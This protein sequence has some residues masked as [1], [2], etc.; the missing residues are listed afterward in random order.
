MNV[1][2]NLAT[3]EDMDGVMELQACSLDLLAS[4]DYNPNQ[5][6]SLIKSQKLARA[7][8]KEIGLAAYCGSKLVGFASLLVEEPR[9]AAIF[10]HPDCTRLGIG[11][12]LIE[13]LEKTAIKRK[14]RRVNVMSSL[15]AVDFYRAMGY[16]STH[17]CGFWSDGMTW[18]QCVNMQKQLIHDT[19]MDRWGQRVI[20]LIVCLAVVAW[21]L[22]QFFQ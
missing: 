2:I 9:I 6:K 18:I 17:K 7:E 11:T 4:K 1:Q 22:M 3:P 13:A 15:T 10:V 16:R 20:L 12:R 14:Y 8:Y 19:A 21:M 5:V